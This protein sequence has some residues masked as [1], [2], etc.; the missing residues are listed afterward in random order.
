MEQNVF[1]LGCISAGQ[2]VVV[3]AVQECLR[4]RFA[5]LGLFQGRKCRILRNG[6]GFVI[7]AFNGGRLALGRDAAMGILVRPQG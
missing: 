4:A 1:P 7:V 3:V 2:N 6:G 5:E